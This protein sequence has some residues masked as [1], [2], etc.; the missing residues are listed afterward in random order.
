M[1]MVPES[2]RPRVRFP[3][4]RGEPA[5]RAPS[6]QALPAAASD[7]FPQRC[8]VP[9][10]PQRR[11]PPLR[12]AEPD[13]TQSMALSPFPRRLL[14]L[15]LVTTLTVADT[16]RWP[17]LATAA[18]QSTARPGR[19]AP[20]ETP[21]AVTRSGRGYRLPLMDAGQ[22]AMA[23]VSRSFEA[24][25]HRYAAGHRGVDLRVGAGDTVAAPRAG[26]VVFRG[27]VAGRGVLVLDHGDGLRSTLEPVRSTLDPGARVLAG[28]VVGHLTDEGHGSSGGP[29]LHWGIRTVDG[30]YL[31]PMLLIRGDTIV[32]L[33]PDSA[34]GA[35][36]GV[37]VTGA[38]KP[39][40]S[41]GGPASLP[42]GSERRATP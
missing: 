13:Q 11:S 2:S 14:I 32:L 7:V 21:S 34:D 9:D 19:T 10:P 40:A 17:V 5:I 31:D 28:A 16:V 30:S 6:H 27:S 36:A 18:S 23:L 29:V 1:S 20:R 38:G 37:G 12:T 26:T 33:L 22:D 24:P 25:A 35:E 39:A 41:P 15:L 42:N 8:T 4:R 3:A